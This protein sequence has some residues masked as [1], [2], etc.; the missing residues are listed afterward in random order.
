MVIIT[1]LRAY[2]RA[3]SI[4]DQDS[5]HAPAKVRDLVLLTAKASAE[6]RMN[7]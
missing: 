7:G 3:R 1:A 5:A 6:M 2:D 4:Y